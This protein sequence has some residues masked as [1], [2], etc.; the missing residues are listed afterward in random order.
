M[1]PLVRGGTEYTLVCGRNIVLLN[2]ILYT[3]YTY[4]LYAVHIYKHMILCYYR[5]M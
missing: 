4:I 2:I 5:I 3:V 1:N